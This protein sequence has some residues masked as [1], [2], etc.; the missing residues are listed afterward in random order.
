MPEQPSVLS[1]SPIPKLH[2]ALPKKPNEPKPATLNSYW[3]LLTGHKFRSAPH[4]TYSCNPTTQRHRALW[5][6]LGGC[7]DHCLQKLTSHTSPKCQQKSLS[8][9]ST[10][11]AHLPGC[12]VCFQDERVKCESLLFRQSQKPEMGLHHHI[13]PFCSLGPEKEGRKKHHQTTSKKQIFLSVC[14]P[15]FL[16]Y[17][18]IILE[19]E[20]TSQM[21][22]QGNQRFLSPDNFKCYFQEISLAFQCQKTHL[23][24]PFLSDRPQESSKKIRHISFRKTAPIHF[25]PSQ[26]CW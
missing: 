25:P 20:Q 6:R 3:Y 19:A 18:D 12:K 23:S 1:S 15:A 16:P 7:C 24:S 22:K 11:C 9:L 13:Q 17:E 14:H 4:S 5:D 21:Q 10:I 26:D 8:Q 2:E